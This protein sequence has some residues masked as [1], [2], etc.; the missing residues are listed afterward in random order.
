[1]IKSYNPSCF[2]VIDCRFES[3]LVAIKLPMLW[4]CRVVFDGIVRIAIKLIRVNRKTDCFFGALTFEKLVMIQFGA[5]GGFLVALNWTSQNLTGVG[6]SRFQF[7]GAKVFN[8]TSWRGLLGVVKSLLIN[9]SRHLP[10]GYYSF[11]GQTCRIGVRNH[12]AGIGVEELSSS[13][14]WLDRNHK[15]HIARHPMAFDGV[16][17]SEEVTIVPLVY[18]QVT[19]GLPEF[20]RVIEVNNWLERLQGLLKGELTCLEVSRDQPCM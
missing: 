9:I 6:Y 19:V 13:L 3:K 7:I 1:M 14:L 11:R 18:C 10:A 5:V 8:E 12:R 17:H 16:C 20:G 15:S 2:V 4:N